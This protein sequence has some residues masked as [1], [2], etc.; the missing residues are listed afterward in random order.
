MVRFHPCAQI[1]C[2]LSSV[3]ER[4]VDIEEAVGS[5]PTGRTLF[6]MFIEINTLRKYPSA[7]FLIAANS[8]PLIGVLFF[9][10]SILQVIFIYWLE[11]AVIGFYSLFRIITVN[12]WFSIF[13]GPFFIVHYGGFMLA[14][15]AFILVFFSPGSQNILSSFIFDGEV[16]AILTLFKDATIPISALF[17]SHGASFFINFIGK[18]EYVAYDKHDK[19]K[20]LNRPYKRIALMQITLIFGGLLI[21]TFKIP[22]IGVAVLILLKIIVDLRS[23]IKEHESLSHKS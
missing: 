10:F 6:N 1:N 7:F 17:L 15:L 3:A 20:Q 21:L 8:I 16:D 19:A 23:H 5:I 13:L 9:E 2:A 18:K 11:S 4:F 22:V 14:H 12:K